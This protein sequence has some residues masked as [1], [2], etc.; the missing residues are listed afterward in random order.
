MSEDDDTEPEMTRASLSED[1]GRRGSLSRRSK[2][3]TTKY[4][5]PG[6]SDEDGDD[7]DDAGVTATATHAANDDVDENIFDG[8]I[9]FDGAAEAKPDQLPIHLADGFS[10]PNGSYTLPSRGSS[11]KSATPAGKRT[12]LVDLDDESDVSDFAASF[13]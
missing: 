1:V 13:N 10:A 5:H 11:R 8:M 4:Q 12:K 3:V 9:N 6:S 7:E 2:S